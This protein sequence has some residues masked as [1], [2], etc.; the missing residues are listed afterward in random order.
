MQPEVK[1]TTTVE[2]NTSVAV[3]NDKLLVTADISVEHLR[4]KL[5]SLME[6]VDD[7]EN[8]WKCTVCGKATKKENA[9]KNLRT[10]IET[11]MEGLLYPCN[12]CDIVSRTSATSRKH[13][14]SH[15]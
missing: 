12:K 1:I 15:C 11:H 5:D 6:K 9:R 4:I 2:N 14:K 7:A 8:I 10:H 3:D 13:S